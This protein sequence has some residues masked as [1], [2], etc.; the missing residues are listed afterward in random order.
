MKDTVRLSQ[1]GDAIG[2]AIPPVIVS[3][4]E[5][6]EGDSI[7]IEIFQIYR[8]G[9]V[10]TEVSTFFRRVI[11]GHGKGSLAVSIKKNLVDQFELESGMNI[12]VDITK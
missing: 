6:T 5:L 7:Q 12:G 9:V 8:E 10:P 1:L 3:D 2:F 4:L 11:R